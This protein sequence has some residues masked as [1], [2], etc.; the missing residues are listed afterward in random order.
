MLIRWYVFYIF[1]K[2]LRTQYLNYDLQRTIEI[3]TT[4]QYRAPE[5]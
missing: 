5:T 1:D 3:T 2:Y 4:V